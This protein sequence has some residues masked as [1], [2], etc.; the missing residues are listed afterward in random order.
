MTHQFDPG[1]RAAVE[2]AHQFVRSGRHGHFW[3]GGLAGTGKTTVAQEIARR[4]PSAPLLA[5]T[6][7]AAV[8]LGKKLDRRAYTIHKA[9]KLC[10]GEV[11]NK[12][13]C[14]WEPVFDDKEFS[15]ELVL[16]DECSMV[17]ADLGRDLQDCC[18]QIIAFGDYGQLPPVEKCGPF[19]RGKPD[20]VLEENHRSGDVIL[21][22]AYNVR[23]GGQYQDAGDTFRVIDAMIKSVADDRKATILC[24]KNNTRRMINYHCRELRGINSYT[25]KEGEFLVARHHI[26]DL[27]I[28]KGDKFVVLADREPG[29]TLHLFSEDTGKTFE[30]ENGVV[31]AIDCNQDPRSYVPFFGFG[32][33][34]TVHMA[35]GS[36]WKNVLVIN[37]YSVPSGE[38]NDFKRWCYTAITRAA[39]QVT[40]LHPQPDWIAI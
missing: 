12:K 19:F 6:N 26:R 20:V 39:E 15:A 32:Y 34:G 14:R 40:I 23:Q 27:D 22:Q 35:Q 16:L 24:H 36:E 8:V 31:E 28:I 17:D 13:T 37:D 21:D 2:A 9:I 4:F 38:P 33:C 5:P 25:I 30:I 10:K 1:Q 11:R 29:E 7:R 18:H 3:I